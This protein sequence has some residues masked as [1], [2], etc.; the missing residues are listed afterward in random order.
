[1]KRLLSGNEA[2]AR[3]AYEYG[4]VFASAY[5]GTP[6]TEILENVAQY[7][8]IKSQWSPNEK[9]AMEVA[10]GASLAGARSLCAMK[11][12]GVNV[13]ADP[14][15]TFAFIGVKG[16]FILVSADDPGMH[17]SQNEQD[18]RNLAKFAK[19][20]VLDPADS[21][22]AKDFIRIGFEI[23]EEFDA[24][25]MLRTTTRTSH[26]KGIVEL[27][28][29]ME[30]T[31]TGFEKDFHKMV[32]LPMNARKLRVKAEE[33]LHQLEAFAETTDLNFEETGTGSIGF[34]ASGI[35]YMHLKEVVPDAPVLKIGMPY[36]LPMEKI[37]TFV[38]KFD[39]IIVVE[40]LDPFIEDQIKAA[41][42]Q[43]EGRNIIPGIGELNPQIIRYALE[44]AGIIPKS[45][46]RDIQPADAV[47]RPPVFCPGCPHLGIFFALKKAK[48]DVITG[49]IGCYT[50]AAIPPF[51]AMDTCVCMGASIG[52]AIGIEKAQGSGQGIAAVIG[53]STFAHSGLTGI[54]EAVMNDSRITVII[55]DNSIT[56]MTGGQ[57]DPRS[58]MNIKHE[59]AKTVDYEITARALG[60]EHVYVLDPTDMEQTQE[61]VKRE[62]AADHL[63]VIISQAPCVLYPRKIKREIFFT[64]L[65]NC[66]G[67]SMCSRINCQAITRTRLKT[68]KGRFK[69]Q[70]N[71]DLCTGCGLCIQMCK[72]DAI[73]P[74]ARKGE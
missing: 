13:A 11:H 64:H 49:D 23:S 7:D 59:E 40:E 35:A 57:P 27:G 58:G 73:R 20:P 66:V 10:I 34:I 74:I 28:D 45:Q 37:R 33:R 26:G 21:Q 19:I 48:P 50:L 24:P 52:T 4:C 29:P 51:D 1:M 60:V 15:M 70:I 18:N 65:D 47:S 25:V 2:I 62:L 39:R 41:G 3:G 38:E 61:V 55:S 5:P 9:V 43:V 42:I 6:S 31:V 44:D 53:D 17:S 16:G 71:T 32:A 12:V 14:L 36:P 72:F 46:R 56:A 30:R 69:W 67:C 54:V 22:E 68:E 8:E 63:S